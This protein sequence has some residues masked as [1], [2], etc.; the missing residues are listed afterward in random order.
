MFEN[1]NSSASG[2]TGVFEVDD[3]EKDEDSESVVIEGLS[4]VV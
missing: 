1:R 2:E 4:P 3:E